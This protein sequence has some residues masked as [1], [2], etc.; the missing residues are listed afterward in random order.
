MA[1]TP[2]QKNRFNLTT[3]FIYKSNK[4][5][6]RTKWSKY[7]NPRSPVPGIFQVLLI[8]FCLFLFNLLQLF[9]EIIIYRRSIQYKNKR[10]PYNRM[11]MKYEYILRMV[12]NYRRPHVEPHVTLDTKTSTWYIYQVLLQSIVVCFKCFFIYAYSTYIL[13]RYVLLQSQI[14]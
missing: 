9:I 14:I 6:I 3:K 8:R 2:K 4:N 5:T 12:F 13:D 7:S 1:S 11:V 10:H